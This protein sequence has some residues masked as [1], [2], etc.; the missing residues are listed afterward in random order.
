MTDKEKLDKIAEYIDEMDLA[1]MTR[2]EI[3]RGIEGLSIEEIKDEVWHLYS[4]ISDISF[5]LER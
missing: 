2:A 1:D 3:E 5:T 4:L